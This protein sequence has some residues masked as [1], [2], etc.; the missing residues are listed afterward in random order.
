M[1]RGR[2]VRSTGD[3]ED[4]DESFPPE[5]FLSRAVASEPGKKDDDAIGRQSGRRRCSTGKAGRR[6]SASAA[7]KFR[8]PT[9]SREGVLRWW[10]RSGCTG[11]PGR[12]GRRSCHDIENRGRSISF[13]RAPS[14]PGSRGT[15]AVESPGLRNRLP[16]HDG[17]LHCRPALLVEA[18]EIPQGH[19]EGVRLPRLQRRVRDPGRR[20][21]TSVPL[22]AWALSPG[23]SAPRISATGVR[24]SAPRYS[25]YFTSKG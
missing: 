15:R 3:D 21:T 11:P 12:R 9:K 14:G 7:A 17:H 25:R 2:S 4:T 20:E 13:A 24:R 16:G 23:R 1:S 6:G 19:R 5:N 10:R 22:A 18:A 8:R